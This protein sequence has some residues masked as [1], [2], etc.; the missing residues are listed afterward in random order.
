MFGALARGLP[1]LLVFATFLVLTAELWQVAAA[2]KM[3]DLLLVA[4]ILVAA[5]LVLMLV[6]SN[7]EIAARQRAVTAEEAVR[8]LESGDLGVSD[9]SKDVLRQLVTSDDTE[10]EAAAPV[11]GLARVNLLIVLMVYECLALVPAAVIAT[12][13][14]FAIGRLAV[15]PELAAEWVYGDGTDPALGRT[16]TEAPLWDQP[17]SRVALLLGALSL[18]YL[19][20]TVIFDTERRAEF[21]RGAD[22]ALRQRLAMRKVYMEH[23]A[24]TSNVPVSSP[25]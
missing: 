7:E 11:A 9:A 8:Q 19:A 4:S 10:P 21:F 13:L 15:S 12:V 1:L 17:W 2:L 6:A 23:L 16:F 18:L 5:A 24:P 14:F 3:R 22:G 20:V 25:T